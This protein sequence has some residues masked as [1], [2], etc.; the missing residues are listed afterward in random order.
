MFSKSIIEL[1]LNFGDWKSKG[2]VFAGRRLSI[3]T[4]S[5][6]VGIGEEIHVIHV[7]ETVAAD[8]PTYVKGTKLV[9]GEC[10]NGKLVSN[11]LPEGENPFAPHEYADQ[12][13]NGPCTDFNFH[14]T[15]YSFE[16][17]GTYEIVWTQ[18]ELQS[19]VLR[20]VV[21]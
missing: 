1:A 12:A 18:G 19:N 2:E 11:E 8:L 14:N 3:N 9:Y 20:V 6:S 16:E 15:T 10:I 21:G 4:P 7:L 17:A 5:E 13:L